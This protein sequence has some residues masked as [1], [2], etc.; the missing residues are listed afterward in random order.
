MQNLQIEREVLTKLRLWSEVINLQIERE[1]LAKLR[2]WQ[3]IS[4]H[5]LANWA[6]R[7]NQ[8]EV[9]ASNLKW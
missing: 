8:V 6:R 4:G 3:P 7:A 5:K 1:G 2:L 9:M